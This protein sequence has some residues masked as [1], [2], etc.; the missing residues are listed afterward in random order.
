M[1]GLSDAAHD[2]RVKLTANPLNTIASDMFVTGL[3]API[4]AA[5]MAYLDPRRAIHGCSRRWVSCFSWPVWKYIRM[6][7]QR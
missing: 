1:A 4:V 2:E 5:T 7:G 6:D 3:I